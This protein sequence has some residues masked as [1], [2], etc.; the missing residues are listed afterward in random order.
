MSVCQTTLIMKCQLMTARVVRHR[1]ADDAVHV[2]V[3]TTTTHNFWISSEILTASTPKRRSCL[4][5]ERSGEFDSRR[6]LSLSQG[7]AS[8]GFTYFFTKIHHF[9]SVLR[10]S[11]LAGMWSS[12]VSNGESAAQ[13]WG[14]RFYP[15][16]STGHTALLFHVGGSVLWVNLFCH[17]ELS[18]GAN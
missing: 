6:G 10:F 2:F 14:A 18:M 9:A 16:V 4:A 7:L 1:D 5:R 17:S 11:S 12:V 13:P 8:S 3:A 15:F